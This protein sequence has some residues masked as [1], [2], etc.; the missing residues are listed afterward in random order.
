VDAE[1]F[2]FKN[3]R[4]IRT[5]SQK[6]ERRLEEEELG[7][8]EKPH[9]HRQRESNKRQHCC[10]LKRRTKEW[11]RVRKEQVPFYNLHGEGALGESISKSGT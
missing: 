1:N 9:C 7:D 2:I 4:R 11:G 3:G 10:K 6:F 8:S 5:A